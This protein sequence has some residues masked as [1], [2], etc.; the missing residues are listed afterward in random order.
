MSFSVLTNA[1]G[2]VEYRHIP[3]G[4]NISELAYDENNP[5]ELDFR[6][7]LVV[8]ELPDKKYQGAW[9]IVGNQVIIGQK[10]ITDLQGECKNL[11]D[12]RTTMQCCA[13][14]VVNGREY[15][16]NHD[17][18][19]SWIGSTSSMTWIL[20][21][22]TKYTLTAVEGGEVAAAVIARKDTLINAARAEKDSLP[23]TIAE[24]ETNKQNLLLELAEF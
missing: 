19:L 22:N 17:A 23:D 20:A 16:V 11:I 5:L 12:L 13:N 7:G 14:I 8:D 1:N 3:E 10:A 21:D 6:T 18:M 2:V 4:L 24:L 15:Q 9:E